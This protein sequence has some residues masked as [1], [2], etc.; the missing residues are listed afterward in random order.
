MMYVFR[1]YVCNAHICGA[2]NTQRYTKG[3]LAP[4]LYECPNLMLVLMLVMEQYRRALE[5]KFHKCRRLMLVLMMLM[6]I[7]PAI[8]KPAIIVHQVKPPSTHVTFT[9]DLGFSGLLWFVPP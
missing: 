3:E 5:Q 1:L 6:Y 4:V 2:D 9:H 8:H 7:M